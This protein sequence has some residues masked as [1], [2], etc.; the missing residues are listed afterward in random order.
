MPIHISW[1]REDRTIL[2]I[3]F[4]GKWEL[5][6][7]IEMY[8]VTRGMTKG[9]T[10]RYITFVD[11]TESESIPAKLL[12]AGD[13]IKEPEGTNLPIITILVGM[14]RLYEIMLN[15]IVRI[16]PNSIKDTRLVNTWEEGL[17]LADETLAKAKSLEEK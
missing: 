11:F 7:F 6:E 4:V 1:Y 10:H 3:K 12:S 16:Y 9:T 8:D 14:G 15:L 17:A 5:T 13:K 2:L